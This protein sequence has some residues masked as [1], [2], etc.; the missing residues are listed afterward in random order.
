[1][2]M[3]GPNNH[4]KSNILRAFE[5]ALSTSAKPTAE[6]FFYFRGDDSELWVEL[7]F[8]ALTEQEKTTFKRYLRADGSIRLR[9]SARLSDTGN[10]ELSYN[11]YFQQP[12]EW[13]LRADKVTTLTKREEVANTPLGQMV[14]ESG[15]L[16]K[17]QIEKA[18]NRYIEQ[19]RNELSFDEVLETG[20]FLGQ[21]N[22]GGG[23]LPD[24][25]LI[26]AV[27][28]LADQTKIKTTTTFGRLLNRA[29]TKSDS[30]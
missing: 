13:W 7:T 27:R 15:R 6:D 20:A 30:S 17:A 12:Q 18:Q 26:P 25:Y 1:M 24:F 2:L 10:V 29:I 14:S 22:I 21:K 11:G 16:T 8:N 4:G 28:D 5:F 19:K 3:L 9:K 23:M